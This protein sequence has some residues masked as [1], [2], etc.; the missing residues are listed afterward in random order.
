MLP[1]NDVL[2]NC[3]YIAANYLEIKGLLEVGSQI[4]ANMMKGKKDKEICETLN[5]NMDFTPQV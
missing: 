5:V 1:N 2:F 3:L 4:I